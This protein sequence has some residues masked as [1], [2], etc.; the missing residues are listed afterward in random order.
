MLQSHTCNEDPC[1]W[2]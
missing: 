2:S 1:K